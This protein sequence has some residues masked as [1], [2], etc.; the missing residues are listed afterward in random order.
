MSLSSGTV[1]GAALAEP[2]GIGAGSRGASDGAVGNT[3]GPCVAAV[4]CSA[5]GAAGGV[6][7]G[8]SEL[9]VG[10]ATGR[11]VGL[12][13]GRGGAVG[14]GVGTGRGVGVGVGAVS[15]GRVRIGASGSTGPWMSVAVGVGVGKRNPPGAL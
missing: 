3:D 12:A 10:E 5:V 4:D 6:K 2:V 13:A 11:G 14:V 1:A 9:L 8:G 15:R 7:R